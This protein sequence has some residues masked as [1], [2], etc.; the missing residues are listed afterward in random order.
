MRPEI[1]TRIKVLDGELC[2]TPGSNMLDRL[3][4]YIWGYSLVVLI[5]LSIC[6]FACLGFSRTSRDLG[7]VMVPEFYDFLIIPDAIWA[8]KLS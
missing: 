7:N 5:Y 8:Y 2:G 4:N 6:S 1:T 3:K